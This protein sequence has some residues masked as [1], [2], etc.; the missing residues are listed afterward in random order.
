VKIQ[1]QTNLP[2]QRALAV[3]EALDESSETSTAAN[4]GLHPRDRAPTIASLLRI[5]HGLGTA[6]R[7][8][9][10]RYRQRRQLME[11][12]DRELKDIGITREQAEEEARKAIWKG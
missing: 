5:L 9:R 6:Y 1:K 8:S 7:L 2:T 10:E 3:G 4:A 12:D 11:M